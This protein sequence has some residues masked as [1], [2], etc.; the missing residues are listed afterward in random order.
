MAV[1]A[2]AVSL[3]F[4]GCSSDSSS[5]GPPTTAP[6]TT[7]AAAPSTSS[8]SAASTAPAKSAAA[9]PGKP[10]PVNQTIDDPELG[11]HVVVESVVHDFPTPPSM[12]AVSNREIVLVKVN[13]TAG[14]KYYAGWQSSSLEIVTPEG[15]T[16]SSSTATGLTGAMTAAG[17]TPF[18]NDGDLATGK[19]GT[20]WVGFVV[21]KKD[22]P[23][24]TL[25]MQ[26][27]DATTSDG[28]SIPAKNSTTR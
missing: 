23:T 20:G 4:T 28:K 8:S 9:A 5:S 1:G 15:D 3:V 27:L 24:L 7:S 16:N 13:V 21:Q 26:R 11:D 18:P 25:R 10:I 12:S 22:S 2:L 19:S 17:Y 6:A 14:D